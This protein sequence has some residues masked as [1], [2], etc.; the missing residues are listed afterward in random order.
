MKE[1][2]SIKK[3]EEET[4][5]KKVLTMCQFENESKETKVIFA[6]IA[7]KVE[8][9]KEQ[10]KEYPTNVCKILDDFSDLWPTELPNQLPPMRDIQHAIDLIP[11]A[12]LPNLPAYRMNPTEHDELKRQVDELLTKGF[13]RESLSPCRVPALLTPKKDGSWRMCG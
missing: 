9:F 2:L 12:S 7:R 13:I 5:P 3:S 1:V 8:E 11:D 10:D 4:Q 6:L